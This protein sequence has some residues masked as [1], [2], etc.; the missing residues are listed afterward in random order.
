MKIKYA[1]SLMTLTISLALTA[2]PAGANEINA[3]V[4]K[5]V[6]NTR[7]VAGP[8]ECNNSEEFVT[9]NIVGPEGP[10]GPVGATGPIGPAG[11]PALTIGANIGVVAIT[12]VN[13]DGSGGDQLHVLPGAS[14]V[15]EFDY[16]I[17]DVACP[18]CIDQIQVGIVTLDG[19][20]SP[21]DCAYDGIP[22]AVGV[23]NAGAVVLTAPSSPGTYY[24]AFDR[25]QHFSCSLANAGG[26][27]WNG[28]PGYERFIGGISVY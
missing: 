20:G 11:P 2:I 13:I 4:Q 10:M 21:Q 9:W 17:V 7:I 28:I 22:G 6:G 19:S 15:V 14:I 18:S 3:C 26:N 27:F 1:A 25:S 8:T 5:E 12:S 23:T 16:T 24:I